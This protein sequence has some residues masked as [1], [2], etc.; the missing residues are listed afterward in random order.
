MIFTI[1]VF[2]FGYYFVSILDLLN[3]IRMS[4]ETT[5]TQLEIYNSLY[6]GDYINY[7]QMDFKNIWKYIKLS[8]DIFFNINAYSD[9]RGI[10]AILLI[11][12]KATA[13]LLFVFVGII[14]IV[15]QLDANRDKRNII[16]IYLNRNWNILSITK[17]DIVKKK[18]HVILINSEREVK[19]IQTNSINKIK[20]FWDDFKFDWDDIDIKSVHL[21]AYL[22]KDRF[23]NLDY[24]LSLK[25]Y[26]Y[27]RSKPLSDNELQ[28]YYDFLRQDEV[29][30]LIFNK[31]LRLDDDNNR[32]SDAYFIVIN[33]I[34]KY[35]SP[36]NTVQNSAT[37]SNDEV[38]SDEN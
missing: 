32:I 34:Q 25:L 7:K 18:Y 8:V 11:L 16:E 29:R 33:L 17:L 27:A 9:F 21:F 28:E 22:L 12:E 14:S 5:L 3:Y 37:F 31:K 23:K 26:L 13:M 6:L 19:V 10:G 15:T 35:I 1:F 30:K 4:K 2:A 24:D 38:S 36:N 20:N